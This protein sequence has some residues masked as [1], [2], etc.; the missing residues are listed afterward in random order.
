MQ[1]V[2]S[3]MIKDAH[4]SVLYYN[5][6]YSPE[7]KEQSGFSTGERHAMAQ[8]EYD[9]LLRDAID[10][11]HWWKNGNCFFHFPAETI[12]RC[13]KTIIR[14]NMIE[15]YDHAGYNSFLVY[16]RFKDAVTALALLRQIDQKYEAVT[17]RYFIHHN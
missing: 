12:A 13:L 7:L 4:S 11:S 6:L 5:G 10:Y 16:R 9:R 1:Q 15:A 3:C 14:R 2:L 8:E 17:A